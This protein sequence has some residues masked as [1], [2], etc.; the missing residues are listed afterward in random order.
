MIARAD[1]LFVATYADTEA[2]GRRVDVSHRGGMP[3]FVR[4]DGD[5]LT[6]PDFSGNRFFNT[7]GNMV[8]NP[9]AGL[10]FIDFERGDVLQV[11]GR[12]EV[13]LDSPE[14]ETFAGAERLWRVHVRR[15]RSRPGRWPCAGASATMRRPRWPRGNGRALRGRGVPRT[16]RHSKT[17]RPGAQ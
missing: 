13:V 5:T 11:S 16:K 15:V 7:L 3:G 4:I 9:R 17:P 12:A 8:L 1:T 14:I 6:I 10:L 2:A